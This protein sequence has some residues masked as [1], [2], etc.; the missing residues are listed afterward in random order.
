MTDDQRIAAISAAALLVLLIV[1]ALIVKNI[2]KK[3]KH[4]GIEIARIIE[5][6]LPRRASTA[7]LGF[8]L[9]AFTVFSLIEYSFARSVEQQTL[10]LL[11]WIG[12]CL[13]WGILL[14]ANLLSRGRTSVAYR[15]TKPTDP[16]Q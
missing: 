14:L 4:L 9:V 8:M 10:A 16:V 15:E 2:P 3:E 5:I 6:N 11:F 7:I 12:S 13:F 1:A